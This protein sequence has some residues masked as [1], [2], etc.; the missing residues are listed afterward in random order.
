M[1]N[2]FQKVLENG[3]EHVSTSLAVFV[4]IGSI[5]SYWNRK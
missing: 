2:P 3:Y 5:N 4:P 1:I